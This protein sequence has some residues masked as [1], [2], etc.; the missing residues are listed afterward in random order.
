IPQPSTWLPLESMIGGEMPEGADPPGTFSFVP[1]ALVVH[2]GDFVGVA[3]P[4]Q[5]FAARALAAI[6]AEWQTVP[7]PSSEE[8]YDYLKKHL[9]DT[10]GRV[11]RHGDI[12][13]A[14]PLPE[15]PKP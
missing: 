2:E 12:W 14:T 5:D 15:K 4:T 13:D 1:L 11:G 3:A 6:R 8:L 7:Q 9:G 10:G